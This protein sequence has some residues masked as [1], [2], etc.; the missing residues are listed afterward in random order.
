[1]G[2]EKGEFQEGGDIRTSMTDS[3]RCMAE[4]NRTE[5]KKKNSIENF[6][7]VQCLRLQS[8]TAWGTG[9]IPGW[10][11]KIP[12]AT[13]HSQKPKQTENKFYQRIE[14]AYVTN[15]CHHL[16]WPIFPSR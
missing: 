2:W 7:T 5:K 13:W 8:S 12:H 3:C 16:L 1:M 11:V 15:H 14:M 4:T 6:Q 9:S 10:G